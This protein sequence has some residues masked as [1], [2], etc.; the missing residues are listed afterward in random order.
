MRRGEEEIQAGTLTSFRG[1]GAVVARARPFSAIVA[2]EGRPKRHDG[3]DKPCCVGA[4]HAYIQVR[5]NAACEVCRNPVSMFHR[6][7]FTEIVAPPEP[8]P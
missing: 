1:I 2:S 5:Q 4:E 6:A 8:A 7:G 3:Q